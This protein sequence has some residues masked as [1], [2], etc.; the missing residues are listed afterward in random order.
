VHLA[1]ALAIDSKAREEVQAAEAGEPHGVLCP[2]GTWIQPASPAVETCAD[3]SL[4]WFCTAAYAAHTVLN[5]LDPNRFWDYDSVLR[6]YTKVGCSST[7]VLASCPYINCLPWRLSL[8]VSRSA[9]G[10]HCAH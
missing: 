8:R 4:V 6:K 10:T 1:Q 5:V 7:T 9:P 3:S 2:A